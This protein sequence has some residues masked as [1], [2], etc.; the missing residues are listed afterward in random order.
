MR[1]RSER[2]PPTLPSSSPTGSAESPEFPGSFMAW[3]MEVSLPVPSGH[4]GRHPVANGLDEILSLAQSHEDPPTRFRKELSGA[5]AANAQ[6]PSALTRI[7]P[8]RR[9][10][11]R[12]NSAPWAMAGRPE[13][14]TFPPCGRGDPQTAGP[15]ARPA[16][17]KKAAWN[18]RS[19]RAGEDPGG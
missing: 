1:S 17:P 5:L 19:R 13:A 10:E 11:M 18:S 14:L 8:V 16:S 3:R 9:W 4:G 6:I 12:Q 2:M 7:S 15:P